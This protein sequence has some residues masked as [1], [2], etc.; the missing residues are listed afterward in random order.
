MN[1]SLFLL[2][3]SLALATGQLIGEEVPEKHPPLQWTQCAAPGDCRTING[4]LTVDENGTCC[5]C[6]FTHHF[7]APRTCPRAPQV[8]VEEQSKIS[9]MS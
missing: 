5:I 4:A 8:P 2:L 6:S 9:N 3:T 1:I 7:F